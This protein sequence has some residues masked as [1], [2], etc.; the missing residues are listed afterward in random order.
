L[1]RKERK[2][3]GG[4]YIGGSDYLVKEHLIGWVGHQPRDPTESGSRDQRSRSPTICVWP[5][6]VQQHLAVSPHIPQCLSSQSRRQ[7]RWLAN[8]PAPPPSAPRPPPSRSAMLDPA[9]PLLRATPALSAVPAT[10]R[11]LPIFPT[12]RSTA[13]PAVRPRTRS[14]ST[15][16]S[17]PWVPSP[18][19]A[20]RPPSRVRLYQSIRPRHTPATVL[21][22]AADFLVNMSASADVLAQAKVEIDLAN[23]PEGK[24]VIIK[25][26]GK[27]VFVRHRTAEEIKEAESAKWE[28]LRDPQPDSDRVQK[29]EWLVMLGTSLPFS[30]LT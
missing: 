9:P 26:R 19:S 13:T 3:V 10:T 12:S 5:L 11:T 23:I 8:A 29:P 18:L 25:W 14:S 1:L 6:S 20:Q 27:P 2:Q 24:N 15:S 7:P 4:C 30:Q 22:C 28:S 17:E 16:W 21:T